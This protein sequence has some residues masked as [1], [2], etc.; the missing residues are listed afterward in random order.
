M[1]KKKRKKQKKLDPQQVEE[2]IKVAANVIRDR[3]FSLRAALEDL[4]SSAFGVR[5]RAAWD[6]PLLVVQY[7][8]RAMTAFLHLYHLRDDARRLASRLGL[9][10]V[11]V[12][13]FT[14]GSLPVQVCIR[15]GD[16]WKHGLG[17]R[18]RN[19]TIT[20]GLL[21][22]IKYPPGTVHTPESDALV[23]GA[24]VVDV[25]HGSFSSDVIITDAIHDWI[26]LLA[27]DLNLDLASEV[28][29]WLPRRP[30][31]DAIFI[32]PG[33]HP[34]VPEVPTWLCHSLKKPRPHSQRIFVEGWGRPDSGYRLSPK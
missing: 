12:E 27:S 31:S 15:A 14:E 2:R 23:I 4:K 3:F 6:D 30:P 24:H 16:T 33:E 17:G 29:G 26:R 5:P 19:A 21:L 11:I 9:D 7:Q 13:R 20:N 8:N 18:N 22:V 34:S 32:R 10:P 1:A 28:D 25:D